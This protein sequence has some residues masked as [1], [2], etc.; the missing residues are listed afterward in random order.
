MIYLIGSMKNARIP[1]VANAL[2]EQG[3]D[4]F[5]D[6]YSPGPDAD[7]Y[8]QAYER[9]RGRS[10]MEA[11]KGEHARNV[12]EFDLSHLEDADTV[13][14]LLPAGKSAHLEMGWAVG[15]GKRTAILF[16]EEPERFDI[17]YRFVDE[18][19]MNLKDLEGWL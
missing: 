13:V 2:R 19:F 12:F 18:V 15:M 17:M 11:L 5:D 9:E 3:H 1:E 4:V 10:Y 6:W 8:W 7:D 14:M 16:E